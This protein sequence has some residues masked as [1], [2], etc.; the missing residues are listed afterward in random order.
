L[1]PGL[2]QNNA[3][4]D[5]ER[6]L[7]MLEI[8]LPW[9]PSINHYFGYGEN[10]VYLKA[11]GKEY[12]KAVLNQINA[13]L[14]SMETITKPVKVRVEA[15]MPDKRK[16]DLDNLCKALL[17]AITHAGVWEDDSQIDDLRI[18]RARDEAGNLL[19]GGMVKV[20]IC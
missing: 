1:E 8:V 2:H 11:K 16:R 14:D 4:H 10:R 15:W 9:P 20:R 6:D 7:E 5:R 17:D 12:R 13:Q 3:V 18:Y 19:I